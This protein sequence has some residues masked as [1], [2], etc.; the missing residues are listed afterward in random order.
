M[1]VNRE[2]TL[3]CTS[4]CIQC[5]SNRIIQYVYME[6]QGRSKGRYEEKKKAWKTHRGE[7]LKVD[8]LTKLTFKKK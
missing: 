5:F 4:L 8:E 3:S 1:Q 6:L 2:K 7:T